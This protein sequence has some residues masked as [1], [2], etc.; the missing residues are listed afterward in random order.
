MKR[1]QII[2]IGC[3]VLLALLCLG[4]CWFLFSA[5]T[6]K[7][8]AADECNQ[9]YDELQRIYR[10]KVF[11]NAENIARIKDDQVK[12]GE[13]LVTA[14]NLVHRGDLHIEHKTPT[15]FKQD[16]QATV[17]ALSAHSGSS[18]GKIVASGFNF[19]FDKYL[20][21]SDSLPSAEH[22]DRLA[23]QLTIIEKICKELYAANILELKSV[24]R[25]TFDDVNKD[26][27]L[28]AEQADSRRNRRSRRDRKEPA[29]ANP[30]SA[31]AKHSDYFASQ[32]FEFEFLARPAAFINALNRLAAM[33]L[34]VVVAETEFHK[35]SDP[36][37]VL[38]A[39]NKAAAATAGKDDGKPLVD[40]ASLKPAQRI[41]TDPE[42]EPPVSVKLDIEVYSFEGV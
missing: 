21:Q 41:V 26:A 40:P 8:T 32:R 36:L 11:P 10:A 16:L 12:L 1:Q 6:A 2:F 4:A 18:Q 9:A 25:E 23:G 22:V 13:W 14:S 38:S 24:T 31:H 30:V 15:G 20:G 37:A 17:R 42:L 27:Q 35:I 29:S 5:I 33:D 28:E 19:G 3:S 34:F 7:R 39:A